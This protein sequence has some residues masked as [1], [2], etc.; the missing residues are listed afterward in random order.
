MTD[1]WH[2]L[3]KAIEQGSRLPGADR[4]TL[5]YLMDHGH[6]YKTADPQADFA[7]SLDVIA[8]RTGQSRRQVAYS[9]RH[10]EQH[11]WIKV[12]A[13]VGLGGRNVYELA[14]GEPCDHTGRRHTAGSRSATAGRSSAT[15]APAAAQRSS[16]TGAPEVVQRRGATP[17]VRGQ[18]SEESTRSEV[19]LGPA[20]LKTGDLTACEFCG[21]DGI[22]GVRLVEHDPGCRWLAAVRLYEAER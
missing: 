13:R 6:H 14:I 3:K 7:P 18:F 20:E 5:R 15:A 12:V 11:G 17:Q 16:A 8:E 10:L 22:V 2:Q 21:A 9:I 19:D 1:Q 4:H